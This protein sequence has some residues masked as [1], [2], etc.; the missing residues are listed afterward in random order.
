M[1][2]MNQPDRNCIQP[3]LTAVQFKLSFTHISDNIY[4]MLAEV[5]VKFLIHE[6]GKAEEHK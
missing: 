2:Y 5:R 6:N 3:H 1:Q 4:G